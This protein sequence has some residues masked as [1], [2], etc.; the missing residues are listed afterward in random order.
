MK[1]PRKK[2]IL[3]AK[4]RKKGN[5]RKRIDVI[6]QILYCCASLLLFIGC[7]H[8]SLRLFTETDNCFKVHILYPN[9][10]EDTLLF[11]NARIIATSY[12]TNPYKPQMHLD[13]WE[14]IFSEENMPVGIII[15]TPFYGDSYSQTTLRKSLHNSHISCWAV[16]HTLYNEVPLA[17]G[18]QIINYRMPM[19]TIYVDGEPALFLEFNRQ[20]IAFFRQELNAKIGERLMEIDQTQSELPLMLSKHAKQNARDDEYP[21]PTVEWMI[22][23]H[24]GLEREKARLDSI[25]YGDKQQKIGLR[26]NLDILSD[27]ENLWTKILSIVKHTFKTNFHFY[28]FNSASEKDS[29]ISENNNRLIDIKPLVTAPISVKLS[30]VTLGEIQDF[31]YDASNTLTNGSSFGKTCHLYSQITPNNNHIHGYVVFE[32]DTLPWFPY[33]AIPSGLFFLQLGIVRRRDK[34]LLKIL[35]R[36]I[37]RRK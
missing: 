29:F 8:I 27:Q 24:Q 12:I 15:Q 22:E 13:I 9:Y 37:N 34:R 32:T 36:M 2:K 18:E 1:N 28:F 11:S 35:N 21:T 10:I 19:H 5:K 26:I 33:V 25:K 3:N 30:L 20:S 16:L 31:E 4:G 23:M 7:L 17:F 6:T 14:E